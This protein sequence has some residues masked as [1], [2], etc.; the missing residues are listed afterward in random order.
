[1]EKVFPKGLKIEVVPGAGHFVHQ[2]KPEL[3][4]EVVVKFLKGEWLRHA[5]GSGEKFRIPKPPAFP[6]R[7]VS[8]F[9]SIYRK[10]KMRPFE[11][12]RTS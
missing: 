6:R 2:E 11:S 5:R 7:M 4:N 9:P 1:M 10:I 8:Y 12:V 3:V